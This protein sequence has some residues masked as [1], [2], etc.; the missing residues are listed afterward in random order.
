MSSKGILWLAMF[1]VIWVPLMA[2]PAEAQIKIVN[3]QPENTVGNY[4]FG[5]GDTRPISEKIA[6]AMKSPKRSEKIA[7]DTKAPADKLEPTGTSAGIIIDQN[8]PEVGSAGR[9]YWT[10]TEPIPAGVEIYV[11]ADMTMYPDQKVGVNGKYFENE[12]NQ[13]TLIK[14]L[15]FDRDFDKGWGIELQSGYGSMVVPDYILYTV[16]VPKISS[17]PASRFVSRWGGA[18]GGRVGEI[19]RA[20]RILDK[21]EKNT[22]FG[23]FDQSTDQLVITV[24]AD[25]METSDYEVVFDWKMLKVSSVKSDTLVRKDYAGNFYESNVKI[26]TIDLNADPELSNMFYPGMRWISV[27]SPSGYCDTGLFKF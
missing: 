22:P 24:L 27:K 25:W 2:T 12:Y 21:S 6:S 9:I 3:V 19:I 26:L 16:S 17:T 13:M 5:P 10:A 11:A 7:M 18:I 23:K 14:V 1:I 4:L 20:E 8:M 15:K